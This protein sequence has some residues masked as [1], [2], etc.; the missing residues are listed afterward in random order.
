SRA[1]GLPSEDM[2]AFVFSLR[3][4]MRHENDVYVYREFRDRFPDVWKTFIEEFFDNVGLYPLY[5]LVVSFYTRYTIWKNFP[6]YQGFFMHFLEMIKNEEEEHADIAAFL[7]YFENSQGESL[8]VQTADADA[9]KVL[10]IHKSK[11]LEFPVVILPYLG[12]DIQVGYSSD[13]KQSYVLRHADDDI[14][15][16]KLKNKYYPFSDDLYQI[17]AEEYKKSLM[18]ELNNVYVALTRPQYELYGFIPKRVGNSFNFVKFLLPS[19][20]YIAGE[21]C[22]YGVERQQDQKVDILS[23][24]GHYNWIEYLKEEFADSDTLRHRSQRLRGDVLHRILAN[25]EC[26]HGENLE[27][28]IDSALDHVFMEQEDI[29]EERNEC[30]TMI[31][32]LLQQPQIRPFFECSDAEIFTEKEVIN[33]Y[34]HTKR[35]DRLLVNDTEVAVVDFKSSRDGQDQYQKQVRE[36]MAIMEKIYPNR[37]IRGILIYFDDYTVEEVSRDERE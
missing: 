36:Y 5:E 32:S 8:F 24:D 10:T 17:Y 18:T 29:K 2:H 22:C 12:M 37:M 16:A 1:R 31:M 9:V 4:K 25:I 26:I 30:R 20:N 3:D 14:R 27:E 33:T 34:G 19:E 21:Q 15:L 13:N 7:D 23:C 35:I 6:Q 28:L 11:G